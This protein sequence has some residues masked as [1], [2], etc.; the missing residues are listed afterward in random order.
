MYVCY[1]MKCIV[2]YDMKERQLAYL[3]LYLV[4]NITYDSDYY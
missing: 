3:L 1:I 4:T 2:I